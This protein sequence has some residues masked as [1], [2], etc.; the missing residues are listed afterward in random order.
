MRTDTTAAS[1]PAVIVAIVPAPA[2]CS[3]M[4]PAETANT[5]NLDL[6]AFTHCPD[7]KAIMHRE[8]GCSNCHPEIKVFE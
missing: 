6:H 1:D 8:T 5:Y 3:E 2:V 4:E 7:C